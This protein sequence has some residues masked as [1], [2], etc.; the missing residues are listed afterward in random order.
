[1]KKTKLFKDNVSIVIKNR[2]QY[3]SVR[4]F[5]DL[6]NIPM[7]F[8]ENYFD[9]Y[10]D[11]DITFITISKGSLQTCFHWFYAFYDSGYK[12]ISFEDFQQQ[13]INNKFIEIY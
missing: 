2:E 1:M 5:I 3:N 9:K 6:N 8:N 10:K 12:R 13:Y 7:E 11:K 4:K